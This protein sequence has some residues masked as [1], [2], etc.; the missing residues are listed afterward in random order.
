MKEFFHSPSGRPSMRRALYAISVLVCSACCGF[1]VANG[2]DIQPGVVSVLIGL[3]A[4]TA[5]AALGGRL[6]ERGTETKSSPI[7]QTGDAS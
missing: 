7:T 3:L 5:T 2:R 6:A 1:S 4:S